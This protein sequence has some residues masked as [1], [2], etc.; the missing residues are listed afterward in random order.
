MTGFFLVDIPGFPA[1]TTLPGAAPANIAGPAGAAV[2]IS[3]T[4]RA[5]NT[6]GQPGCWALYNIVVDGVPMPEDGI[7]YLPPAGVS[8][9]FDTNFTQGINI[10]LPPGNHTVQVRATRFQACTLMQAAQTIISTAI[11]RH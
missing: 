8:G 2:L 5:R 9:V 7:H 11:L 4:V 6:S 1:F 10:N 3:Y